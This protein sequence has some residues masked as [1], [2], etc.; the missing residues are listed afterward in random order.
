MSLELVLLAPILVGHLALFVLVANVVHGFGHSDKTLKPVKLAL[1][2]GCLSGMAGL[3]LG[4]WSSSIASWSWP[5]LVY[6]S[7]CLLIG[8]V[9]LPIASL[10]LHIR[11]RPAGIEQ[12][13]RC[14]ISRAGMTARA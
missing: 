4:A 7:L 14:S 9:F 13:S 10:Y 2:L 5:A 6:S 8:L 11:P 3:V 12:R 1:L